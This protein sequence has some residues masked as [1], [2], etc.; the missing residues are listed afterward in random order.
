MNRIYL[1]RHGENT[2][3]ITRE[4]SYKVVDYSLTPRGIL[5]AEQT[6]LFFRDKQIDEIYASPLKRARETA[7]IIAKENNLPV[8]LKEQFREVN[9]GHLELQPPSNENWMLHDRIVTAWLLG[10]RELAFPGGEN[11]NEMLRR[12]REGLQEV[13]AGKDEKNIIIVGHS[14]I[15]TLTLRDICLNINGETFPDKIKH[16]CSITEIEMQLIDR[17]PRGILKTWAACDH[18]SGEAAP[19]L[20]INPYH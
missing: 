13:L 15:F 12:M 2:A 18:L 7:E 3:N 8:T 16:N 14:G 19:M 4:F 5:Q 6:A 17:Q 20:R 1:V 9:V 11:Y 10:N